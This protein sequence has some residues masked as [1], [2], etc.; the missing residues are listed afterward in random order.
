ML[1]STVL[2][3]AVSCV[4]VHSFK[5]CVPDQWEGVLGLTEGLVQNGQPAFVQG[6]VALSYDYTN[7][8][9]AEYVNLTTQGVPTLQKII[10]DYNKNVMYTIKEEAKYCRAVQPA[11]P[12]S[13]CVPDTARETSRFH[14]GAGNNSLK[15]IAYEIDVPDMQITAVT[16]MTAQ[17]CLPVGELMYGAANNV[18]FLASMGYVNIV[19]GIKDPSVFNVPSYCDKAE[20]N[21]VPG[22][23]T[24]NF[25]TS[26]IHRRLGFF[27]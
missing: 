1:L 16:S 11:P 17:D 6:Y 18:P 15:V 20:I 22:L 13:R 4:A 21:D 3:L 10:I 23:E 2:V 24:G 8:R 25:I 5:C 12:L 19:P 26:Y 14:L 7:K 27:Q 9:V